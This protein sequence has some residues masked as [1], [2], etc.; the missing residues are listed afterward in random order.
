MEK[1]AQHNHGVALLAARTETDMFFRCVW[2]RAEAVLF[3][4]GRPHFHYPDGRRAKANSGAPIVLIAYGEHASDRLQLS[5]LP[6]R[7]IRL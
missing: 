1:M 7:F 6:G 4:R 5:G 2:G 3:L